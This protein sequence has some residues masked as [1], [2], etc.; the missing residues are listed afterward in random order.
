MSF[1]EKGNIFKHVSRNR[2]ILGEESEG[3]GS[4]KDVKQQSNSGT[5]KIVTNDRHCYKQNDFSM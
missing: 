5:I 1:S 2:D 3:V 4:Q